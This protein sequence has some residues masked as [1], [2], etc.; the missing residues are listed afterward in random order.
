MMNRLN[1]Q[2]FS[3]A[4]ESADGYI[5]Q[6]QFKRTYR[7]L[8]L[9]PSAPR[10]TIGAGDFVKVEA[11]RGEDLGIV[12][13]RIA[14]ADFH[15][16]RPTAGYRGRGGVGQAENKR[17]LRLASVEDKAQLPFKHMEEERALYVCCEKVSQRKLPMAIVDASYQFD[18]HKLTFYFEADHRI[19]FRELVSDLFAL[20]KTRIW[21]QQIDDSFKPNKLYSRALA[22]GSITGVAPTDPSSLFDPMVLTPSNLMGEPSIHPGT[23]SPPRSTGTTIAGS[24]HSISARGSS[25]N[26]LGGINLNP[27]NWSFCD[28]GGAGPGTATSSN[29][30]SAA[31][32]VCSAMTDDEA[33]ASALPLSWEWGP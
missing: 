8:V 3:I 28:V 32:S 16:E 25:S 24:K 15:D 2:P 9:G 30:P 19:D 6:V 21:M 23:I 12:C 11:D 29:V 5:Y 22:T 33:I 4:M 13:D 18:R 20:Y 14:A 10:N 26:P 27:V 7:W 31:A 17:I 1:S